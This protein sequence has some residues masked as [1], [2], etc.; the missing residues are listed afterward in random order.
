VLAAP[1]FGVIE[2]WRGEPERALRRRGAP[3]AMSPLELRR[4]LMH[5]E[6]LSKHALRTLPALADVVV[7]LDASRNV[8]RVRTRVPS[9]SS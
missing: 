8:V 2:R 9:T 5:Y 6:R 7:A 3:R 4:F 1:D